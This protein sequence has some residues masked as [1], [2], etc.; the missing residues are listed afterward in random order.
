MGLEKKKKKGEIEKE[1]SDSKKKQTKRIENIKKV[2]NDKKIEVKTSKELKRGGTVE[3]SKAI[4]KGVKKAA[5]VTNKEFGKQE[6]EVKK[7]VFNPAKKRESELDKRSEI[8]KGD[9][10]KLK[11]AVSK[12]DTAAAKDKMKEA[13]SAS[14]DDSKFLKK[15]E[16]D[17][18]KSRT[19]GEKETSRQKNIVDSHKISF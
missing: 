16:K 14:K 4:E 15:K 7:E 1:I 2:A 18:Q 10:N 12:M 9:A 3:G 19:V 6:K 8:A 5:E 13:V 11:G 17:Q